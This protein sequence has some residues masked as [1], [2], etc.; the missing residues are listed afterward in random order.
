MLTKMRERHDDA[1]I[2]LLLKRLYADV[3]PIIDGPRRVE[4]TWRVCPAVNVR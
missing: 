3:D 1:D 4:Y 2:S